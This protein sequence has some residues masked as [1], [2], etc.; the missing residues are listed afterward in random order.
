MFNNQ[1]WA[2]Y[3]RSAK[4]LDRLAKK[5]GKYNDLDFETA[6]SLIDAGF[7][8]E[9]ALNIDSF[10]VRAHNAIAWALRPAERT[11][12]VLK[13]IK[14]LDLLTASVIIK[15][16]KGAMVAGSIS[17]FN[18]MHHNRIAVELIENG[19]A[20]IVKRNV[21]EF[22]SLTRGVLDMLE[23]ALSEDIS[24][25]DDPN[26]TMCSLFVWENPNRRDPNGNPPDRTVRGAAAAWMNYFKQAGRHL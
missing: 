24:D 14:N 8:D 11:E 4:K 7:S 21:D 16:K 25:H 19:H 17:S 3:L 23:L 12:L 22:I 20:S 26:R 10:K 5:L 2:D 1:A 13:N 6:D 18:E 15:A 9:V